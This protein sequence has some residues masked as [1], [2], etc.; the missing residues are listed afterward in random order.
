[1]HVWCHLIPHRPK[2]A[3]CVPCAQLETQS[4]C[5]HHLV[6]FI[7]W[8]IILTVSHIRSF[9]KGNAQDWHHWAQGGHRLHSILLRCDLSR[10]VC[11]EDVADVAIDF[12]KSN[13]RTLYFASRS[14][15]RNS[16][17]A[18]MHFKVACKCPA[19]LKLDMWVTSCN[20]LGMYNF[21][22]FHFI[23]HD[24]YTR[25]IWQTNGILRELRHLEPQMTRSILLSL[26]LWTRQALLHAKK[27]QN[28]RLHL[29]LIYCT[30][31]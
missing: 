13:Q 29:T 11:F 2:A 16:S 15:K 21:K 30:S 5:E 28:L 3:D 9:L 19:S 20:F 1:M 22:G 31:I 8:W 4:K 10:K 25:I 14:K 23:G 24:T 6:T 18:F 17:L 26:C 27:I 7:P 12:R